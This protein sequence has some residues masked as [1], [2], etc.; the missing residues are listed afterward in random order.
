MDMSTERKAYG[1]YWSITPFSL[2]NGTLNSE[3]GR[4]EKIQNH[5]KVII[6]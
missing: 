4:Y 1:Y 6:S 3:I 2:K 5:I